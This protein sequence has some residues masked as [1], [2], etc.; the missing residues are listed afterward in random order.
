RPQTAG[1]SRNGIRGLA[2]GVGMAQRAAQQQ[3]TT[4]E[5]NPASP[6]GMGQ[7]EGKAISTGMQK[8]G[9]MCPS[10]P[11]VTLVPQLSTESIAESMDFQGDF[12]ELQRTNSDIG[13]QSVSQG[14]EHSAEWAQET[15]IT[16]HNGASEAETDGPVRGFAV[17][18]HGLSSPTVSASAKS[19]RMPPPTH[20]DAPPLLIALFSQEGARKGGSTYY[21]RRHPGSSI[22]SCRRIHSIHAVDRANRSIWR[23]QASRRHAAL[24]AACTARFKEGLD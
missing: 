10:D 20:N 5:P 12:L 2:G 7:S 3:I 16:A 22:T 18:G 1:P 19:Q 14:A 24:Q 23:R 6:D 17:L 8:K 4:M 9:K 21:T 11:S 13:R 15:L